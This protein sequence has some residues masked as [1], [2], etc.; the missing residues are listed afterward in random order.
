MKLIYEKCLGE[1]YLGKDTLNMT[2]F[3]EHM[4][5]KYCYVTHVSYNYNFVHF[6]AD[7][8]GIMREIYVFRAIKRCSVRE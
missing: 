6:T 8:S 7:S 2:T 5:N 4:Y 1:K 3:F